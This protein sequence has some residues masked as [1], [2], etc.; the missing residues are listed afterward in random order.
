[1]KVALLTMFN[2]LTSTYSLVNVVAEQLL[3]LLDENIETKVLVSQ[4]CPDDQRYGIYT[5][6]RIEWIKISNEMDGNI[7]HWRDYATPTGQ[8]HATFFKEVDHFANEYIKHLGDVDACIMHDIHF[9]GWHLVHN[10]AIRKAQKE[11]PN[12]KFI[13]FTHSAPA[14]KPLKTEWPFSARYSPMPNTLYIYPTQSGIPALAKQYNVP[15]EKCRVVNNTLDLTSFLSD[16]VR[17]V[18]NYIDALSADILVVYPGRLSKAKKFDK[19][20]LLCGSI[21]KSSKLNVKVIFCD[22]PALDSEVEKYKIA[23]EL[24]GLQNGL[25]ENDMVFTSDLGF[26][27][28]FPRSEVLE[29][30]S[31]SNLFICPSFSE[32]FGLTVLEA[33]CKGNL[34]VLNE[35]VPALEE[36]GKTLD[37]YF[38]RWDAHNFGFD[39]KEEYYPSEIEYMDEHAVKIIEL[40]NNNPVLKAKTLARTRFSP[41]WVWV[42]QLKPLLTE[43]LPCNE[44]IKKYK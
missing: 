29:L 33:A 34:L 17:K 19:V 30:L 8:V 11:L 22:F 41:N 14:N 4:H 31:L 25:E 9:Q 6:E 40:I 36:L 7:I 16:D 10:V 27:Y 5:D 12:L 39:T 21:K 43:S 37:A 26:P 44:L 38:M 2:G 35:A 24:I 20:A 15:E 32:S 42:N 1:M 18:V 28:G 13:A 23:V 3:M